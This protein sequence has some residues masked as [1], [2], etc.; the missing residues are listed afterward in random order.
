MHKN[1]RNSNMDTYQRVTTQR[2]L[3]PLPTFFCTFPQEEEAACMR[4]KSP[5]WKNEASEHG[6]GTQATMESQPLQWESTCSI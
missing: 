6:P 2:M 3:D 5:P 4:L 1:D